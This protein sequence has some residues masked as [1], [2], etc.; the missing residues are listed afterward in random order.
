MN[1]SGDG[2]GD[3]S[4]P[5]ELARLRALLRE[6][7]EQRDAYA[8]L[9]EGAPDAMMIATAEG[10]IIH[11]NAAA[12]QLSG[13]APGSLF[14]FALTDLVDAR[15]L[16]ERPLNRERVEAGETV[17]NQRLVLREG[18][19]SMWVETATSKLPDG[20]YQLWLRD[21][22]ARRKLELELRNAQRLEA[23][24]LLAAG[25]AHDLNNLL[26]VIGGHAELIAL[27]DGETAS[28]S[29]ITVATER[30]AELTRKLLAF[31]RV[32][33]MTPR[34]LDLNRMVR[35][36]LAL[37]RSLA[38]EG[39]VVEL[40]LADELDC[41][42]ADSSQLDQ[43]LWNLVTNACQAMGGSGTLTLSTRNVLLD[44]ESLRS[45]QK[46]RSDPRF[47]CL[48]VR[49]TGQGM[50]EST[51][52][53]AFDPFFTTRE[54]GSGLGLSVVH[55]IVGQ[56]GGLVRI[57]TQP[58]RG[59]RFDVLLP[60]SLKRLSSVPPLELNRKV[61]GRVKRTG[62]LLVV[63]DEPALRNW[64][65]ILLLRHGY[66]VVT[67]D[68]GEHALSLVADWTDPPL[69]VVSDVHMPKLSGPELGARLRT[70]WPE[71][72]LLFISGFAQEAALRALPVDSGWLPK[73]FTGPALLDALERL[74]P[75]EA[76]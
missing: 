73:P 5:S 15:D 20:T 27:R 43:A 11:A 71:L 26:T 60:V 8:S 53:R 37:V 68:D 69:A 63:E 62:R 13:R 36:N 33:R 4:D 61:D 56:H 49:D 9:V 14:G 42:D 76:P 72:S 66:E 41:V 31:G 64:L 74:M 57:D 52:A 6:A 3:G 46:P 25:L 35:D 17:Y 10:K 67:A 59:T 47:V 51:A 54:S 30:A 24:G 48:S 40:A 2:G 65:R 45:L 18:K 38:G 1:A 16:Q 19:E 34:A 22:S 55:G 50:D 70:R 44:D 12:H 21:L 58:A 39:I 28:T 75:I 7:T 32:Q 29:T 23:T